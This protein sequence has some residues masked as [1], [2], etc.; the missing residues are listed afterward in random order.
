MKG[1]NTMKK[2][3]WL[4]ED[5]KDDNG[6]GR[7]LSQSFPGRRFHDKVP[8]EITYNGVEVDASTVISIKR[9]RRKHND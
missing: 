4:G 1:S 8:Y 6:S 9:A 2:T 5:I 3:Y 7:S